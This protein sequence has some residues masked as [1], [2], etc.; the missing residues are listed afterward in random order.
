[1]A[2]AE[3]VLG[4]HVLKEGFGL[5]MEGKAL[6]WFQ[7]LDIGSYHS[8][9]ALER[10]FIT[11]FI[12]TGI[13]HDVSN[14]LTN[15]K[16]NENKTVKD[17]VNQFKQYLA[18]CPKS[19]VSSQAKIISIFLEGLKDKILRANLYGK[20]HKTINECIQDAIGL[21]DNCD[22]YGKPDS[23]SKSLSQSLNETLE[24]TKRTYT[25]EEM[26]EMV[27]EKMRYFYKSQPM[28]QTLEVNKWCRFKQ[29]WT[30]HETPE[31]HLRIRYL[32]ETTNAKSKDCIPTK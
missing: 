13:K 3:E 28:R 25:A 14:L 23:R 26:V 27:M 6:S 7:T 17:C 21:N 2:R 30:D 4:L 1:M 24:N 5:T 11:D 20:K 16:Q 15:F 9:E 19:E 10:E 12:R 29:G 31:C 32:Q 8:F 22:I 18:R